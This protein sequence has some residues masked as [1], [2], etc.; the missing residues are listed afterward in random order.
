MAVTYTGHSPIKMSAAADV[1]SGRLQVTYMRWVAATAAGHVLEVNDGNGNLVW[2]GEADGANFNDIMP[3]FQEVDG[4][5][6]ATMTSGYLL[7][8]Y[9]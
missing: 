7:V 2:S 5:E 3:L 4:L 6:V 1:W 8:Y 9:R